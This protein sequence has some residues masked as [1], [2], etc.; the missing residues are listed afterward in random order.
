MFKECLSVRE[1]LW[2]SEINCRLNMC[3]C[4]VVSN[5]A[6]SHLSLPLRSVSVSLSRLS[7]SCLV[8]LLSYL[9][10]S[11]VLCSPGCRV[12]A[13]FPTVD[14]AAMKDRRME[15]LVAYAKKVEGDMYESAN[16]RVSLW[17]QAATRTNLGSF[18]SGKASDSLF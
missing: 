7:L 13:I 12:Q 18:T 9:S 17:K 2:G 4:I 8:S 3:I 10:L 1:F 6:E 15:N 11:L 16:S 14:A 5:T